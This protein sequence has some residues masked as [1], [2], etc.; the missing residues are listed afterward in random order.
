MVTLIVD[1]APSKSDFRD[2]LGVPSGGAA[3][4]GACAG[5][6]GSLDNDVVSD[7]WEADADHEVPWFRVD[8]TGR[9]IGV[10]SS[11]NGSVAG[12]AW[13]RDADCE[14]PWLEGIPVATIGAHSCAVT[15][16][17]DGGAVSDVWEDDGACEIP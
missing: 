17:V 2:R 8:T 9:C 1:I 10:A 6:G 4:D 14:V 15:G 13:E 16:S 11:V 7:A 5:R 12:N 3:F